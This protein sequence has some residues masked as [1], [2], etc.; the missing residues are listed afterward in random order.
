LELPKF[1]KFFFRDI[2]SAKKSYLTALTL[3]PTNIEGNFAYG[4]FLYRVENDVQNAIKHHLIAFFQNPA[5]ITKV[6]EF[7]WI[8]NE[9]KNGIIFAKFVL[10]SY[11][12]HARST[13]NVLKVDQIALVGLEMLPFGIILIN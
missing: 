9:K 12:F 8:V 2:E 5:L 10:T 13:R 11:T 4:K 1:R 6:T 7:L 3:W